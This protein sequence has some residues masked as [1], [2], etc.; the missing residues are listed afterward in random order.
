[1]TKLLVNG[2]RDVKHTVNSLINKYNE[3]R[4]GLTLISPKRYQ[5]YYRVVLWSATGLTTGLYLSS[6]TLFI[7]R[8]KAVVHSYTYAITCH[9][10]SNPCLVSAFLANRSAEL[11]PLDPELAVLATTV[12]S[13]CQQSLGHKSSDLVNFFPSVGSEVCI[14]L[15]VCLNA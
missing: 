1:M 11:S 13:E 12:W 15:S 3:F 7:H 2:L 4:F 9:S 6:Q 14:V 10:H 8:L 5:Y